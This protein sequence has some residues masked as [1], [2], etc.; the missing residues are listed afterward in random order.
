MDI[1]EICE[2]MCYI[3]I[4]CKCGRNGRNYLICKEKDSDFVAGFLTGKRIRYKIDHLLVAGYNCGC[5]LI[6]GC[7]ERIYNIHNA[8]FV[9]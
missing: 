9:F 6:G 4:D 8:G 2:K 3:G 1:R 7:N 5:D